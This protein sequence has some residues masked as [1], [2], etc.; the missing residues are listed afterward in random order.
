MLILCLVPIASFAQGLCGCGGGGGGTVLVESVKA[1]ATINPVSG[2]SPVTITAG[3]H[4][5]SLMGQPATYYSVVYSGYFL[6]DGNIDLG[7]KNQSASPCTIIKTDANGNWSQA[8]PTSSSFIT[9]T[10]GSHT[11]TVWSDI[12]DYN[13]PSIKA[14]TVAS[15]GFTI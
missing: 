10:S 15:V 6:I 13:T 14:H 1:N 11:A 5:V 9:V 3:V 8:F 7:S 2:P 4:S 12:F